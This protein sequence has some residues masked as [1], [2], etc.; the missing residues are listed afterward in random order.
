[1]RHGELPGLRG[2]FVS[3]TEIKTLPFSGTGA[4]GLADKIIKNLLSFTYWE[5]GRGSSGY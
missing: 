5:Y 4:Y 3:D 2:E 1:M